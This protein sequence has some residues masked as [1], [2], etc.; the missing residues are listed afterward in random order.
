MGTTI[1]YSDDLVSVIRWVAR[2][3]ALSLAVVVL[4]FVSGAGVNV[5]AMGSDEILMSAVFL[6]MWLGLIVAWRWEGAGGILTTGGT[7][8]YVLLDYFLTGH[9]LRFWVFFVF[10]IPGLLFLYCWWRPRHGTKGE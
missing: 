3:I 4:I 9:V 2:I 10:L 7:A 5:S 1:Q 6:M 8:L